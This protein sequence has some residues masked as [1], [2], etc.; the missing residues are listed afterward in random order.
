MKKVQELE[1]ITSVEATDIDVGGVYAIAKTSKGREIK[2]TALVC[3]VLDLNPYIHVS[4]SEDEDME[5]QIQEFIDN[6]NKE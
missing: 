6:K 1:D 5:D 3:G 2:F 4:S